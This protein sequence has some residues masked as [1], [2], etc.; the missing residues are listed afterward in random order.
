MLCQGDVNAEISIA[1]DA[2]NVSPNYRYTL[3]KYNDISGAT[4]VQS[5]VSQTVSV[6]DNLGRG[7]Y[8]I[9][10]VDD[11]NCTFES[12]IVEVANPIEVNAILLTTTTLSCLTAAELQLTATGGTAPYTFSVDGVTFGAM[13]EINGANTHLVQ[14]LPAGSYQYFIRDNLN[15]ISIISNEVSISPIE[16][17]RLEELDISAAVINCNGESTAV[18]VANADGGLGNY[19]YGLF[20]DLGLVNE[21]RPYQ[22]TGTFTDLGAGTYYVSV[23]SEDC[24]F[25]SKEL[26]ITEPLLLTISSIVTNATCKGDEDGSILLTVAGGSGDYQFAISPNLNQFDDVNSFDELAPGDY[27][28]IVQDSNGCFDVIEFTITEPEILEMESSSTP[29]ICAG[30]EDGTISIIIT[31]GTAPYSTSVNSNNDSDFVEGRLT[32]DGFSRRH[33]YH[34]C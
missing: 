19:Q 31:G 27:T 18:I 26:I 21:I 15:C 16:D 6:F 4:L 14:N 17:L 29:E 1:L 23:Q 32:L 25:I 8:N 24:Q 12:V 30:N 2:R 11:L 5:S 3:N 22:N 10:V 28:V 33:L 20:S 9:S 34:I 7:F 13:N